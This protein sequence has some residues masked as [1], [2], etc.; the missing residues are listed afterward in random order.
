MEEIDISIAIDIAL[1]VGFDCFTDL[2]GMLGTSKFYRKLAA[3]PTVLRHVSLR[4]LFSNAQF[5]NL[6]SPYKHFFSLCLQAGNS[7]A[8]YLESLKLACREGNAEYALQMLETL[9]DGP[10]HAAFAKGLLQQVLGFFDEALLTIDRFVDSVG[11]FH[12]ADTIGSSVFRQIMKI[13]PR[14]VRTHSNTWKYHVLPNCVSC[15]LTNRCRTCFF[16][17]FCVMFLLLC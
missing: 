4:Y 11:S 2:G 5:I 3:D 6:H 9:D 1:R 8:T 17:W 13:G 10:P 7:T 16:Y 12:A 15:S 14:K